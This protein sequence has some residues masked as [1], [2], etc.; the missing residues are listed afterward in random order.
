VTSYVRCIK[1]N[2]LGLTKNK[3]Y[4]VLKENDEY[5]EILNNHLEE[6][7]YFNFRFVKVYTLKDRLNLIKELI[8]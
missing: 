5:Y 6:R 8:K 3:V 7:S 1:D 4:R 2:V